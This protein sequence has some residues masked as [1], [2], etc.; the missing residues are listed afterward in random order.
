MRWCRLSITPAS[1][2]A[3]KRSLAGAPAKKENLKIQI[4]EAY[5]LLRNVNR[6]RFRNS[7]FGRTTKK[8]VFVAIVKEDETFCDDCCS[9]FS[10]VF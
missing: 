4:K 7:A 3:P 5:A 8:P 1:P 2:S 9:L 6:L 10:I